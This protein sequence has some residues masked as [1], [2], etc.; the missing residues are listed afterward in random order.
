LLWLWWSLGCVWLEVGS[1]SNATLSVGSAL[2]GCGDIGRALPREEVCDGI[3]NDCDGEVDE[4]ELY[5]GFGNPDWDG[6]G[7]YSTDLELLCE[8]VSRQLEPGEDCN[9]HDPEVG[10]PVITYGD[11][12]G[13]GWGSAQG[14]I[15]AEFT[16]PDAVGRSQSYWDCDDADPT[17]HPDAI[18]DCEDGLD[19]DCDGRV[20]CEDGDCASDVTCFEQDCGDEV[21]S[22][23]DGM[24]DCMDEDCWLESLCDVTVTTQLIAGRVEA[25]RRARTQSFCTSNS[26]YTETVSGYRSYQ[27]NLE[28]DYNFRREVDVA[29]TDLVGRT[30]IHNAVQDTSTTCSWS[31]PQARWRG[32]NHCNNDWDCPDPI[33]LASGA[34]AECW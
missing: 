9:D 24:T 18:E 27:H 34:A 2:V 3:D 29:A 8:Q 30:R 28:C 17:R 31:L 6:D 11:V 23:D 22:D 10:E 26:S 5:W 4:G 32:D 12:D 14:G 7:F 19:S 15:P 21:D 16:C 33:D 20:D 13:D 1:Q 25:V